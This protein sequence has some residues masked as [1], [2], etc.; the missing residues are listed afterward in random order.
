PP[1]DSGKSLTPG[2]VALIQR[3]VAQ[4]AEYQGHWAYLPPKRPAVPDVPASASSPAGFVRNEVDRF[5]LAALAG[6]GLRPSPEADRGTLT[7]R[8]SVAPR[9][10]PPPP[11]EADAFVNNPSPGAYERLVDRMLASPQYGERMA[12]FWL[13]LVRYAD[14]TGYHGD[15]HRDVA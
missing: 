4:G 13:D 15:N 2:Q 14:T 5:I 10:L 9:G 3:W 8:L 7:R 1:P 12:T 11:A 6:K